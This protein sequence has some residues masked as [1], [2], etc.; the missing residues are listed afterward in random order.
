VGGPCHPKSS[1]DSERSRSPNS[2]N[3]LGHW[4]FYFLFFKKNLNILFIKYNKK[5]IYLT[6]NIHV[7]HVTDR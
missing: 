2:W 7:A 4:F 5:I 6:R 1:E 3:I